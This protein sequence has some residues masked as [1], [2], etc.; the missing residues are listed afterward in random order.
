MKQFKSE[1][2]KHWKASQKRTEKEEI[3]FGDKIFA[4]EDKWEE[5]DSIKDKWIKKSHIG[6]HLHMKNSVY[7][8]LNLG[9]CIDGSKFTAIN[10]AINQAK[11]IITLFL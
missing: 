5:Y 1:Y 11:I 10:Q 9:E 6:C 4:W 2:Y 3:F 8:P 7:Q